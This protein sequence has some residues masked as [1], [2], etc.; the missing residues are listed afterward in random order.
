MIFKMFQ[1][2]TK[3]LNI[4]VY[5][6]QGGTRQVLSTATAIKWQLFPECDKDGDPVVS[7]SLLDGGITILSDAVGEYM[8]I[9]L[10]PGDT[11]ALEGRY[12]YETEV[13]D[14]SG[15]DEVV[16]VGNIDIERRHVRAFFTMPSTVV[17]PSFSVPVIGVT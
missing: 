4:S 9:T 2:N 14:A 5:D 3:Y 7:K 6:V 10:L 13:V 11:H 12:Y 8:R 17:S 1:G 15:N 16:A